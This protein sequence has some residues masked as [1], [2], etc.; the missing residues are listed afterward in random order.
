MNKTEWKTLLEGNNPSVPMPWY[1]YRYLG[2]WHFRFTG[3]LLWLGIASIPLSIYELFTFWL[4]K[5]T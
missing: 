1:K 2:T 3:A 5:I 4:P